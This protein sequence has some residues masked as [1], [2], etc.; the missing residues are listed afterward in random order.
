MRVR[1]QTAPHP[2]IIVEP[3]KRQTIAVVFG[4]SGNRFCAVYPELA[5]GPHPENGLQ[6]YK[7]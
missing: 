4:R 7:F 1:Y 5:E 2:E 6:K 3:K